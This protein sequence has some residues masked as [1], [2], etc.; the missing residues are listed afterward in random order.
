MPNMEIKLTRV[1]RWCWQDFNFPH[2]LSHLIIEFEL[3]TTDWD[4][5]PHKQERL[6]TAVHVG[7]GPGWQS[8]H[9]KND[10]KTSFFFFLN[11]LTLNNDDDN[12]LISYLVVSY[13]VLHMNEEFLP[14]EMV[15]YFVYDKSKCISDR[16]N[17]NIGNLDNA[18]SY[19]FHFLHN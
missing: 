6:L 5:R 13:M 7:H 8:L 18:N 11:I 17:K 2:G 10:N 19:P 15:D 12:H 3:Q 9:N 16:S 14:V 4:S 1:H